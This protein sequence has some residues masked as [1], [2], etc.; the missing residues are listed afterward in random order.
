MSI[1]IAFSIYKRKSS[2][3]IPNM[4]LWEFCQETQERVR[5]SCGKQ[6][7][8]VRATEGLLYIQKYVE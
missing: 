6:A 7:I 8:R 1:H 4:Q 5:N 2:K 3:I